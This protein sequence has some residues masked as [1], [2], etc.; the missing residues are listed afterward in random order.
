[1]VVGS[2]MAALAPVDGVPLGVTPSAPAAPS[3]ASTVDC[4][5]VA[6]TSATATPIAE[7]PPIGSLGLAPVM[8]KFDT[9][10]PSAPVPMVNAALSAGPISAVCAVLDH[11][12]CAEVQLKPPYT[13]RPAVRFTASANVALAQ[14]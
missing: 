11:V 10:A 14:A 13:S 9:S 7:P 1:M 4:L 6:I 5:S 3:F 2:S 8:E 12:H